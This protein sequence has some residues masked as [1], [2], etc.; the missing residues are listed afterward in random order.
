AFCAALLLFAVALDPRPAGRRL[1][2]V[3]AGLAAGLGMANHNLTMALLLPVALAVAWTAWHEPRPDTPGLALRDRRL[4]L[5][6]AVGLGLVRLVRGP[7]AVA[8][9]LLALLANAAIN[10]SACD[11][12]G[13]DAG[14]GWIQDLDASAPQRSVILFKSWDQ[15]MLATYYRDRGFRTDLVV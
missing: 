4:V 14:N 10:W 1:P 2:F 11:R 9:A 7:V 3:L 13:F 6:L 8:A 5:S 12:S 15:R